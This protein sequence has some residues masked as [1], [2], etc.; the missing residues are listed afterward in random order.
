M[1][2]LETI[3]FRSAGSKQ[4]E[5]KQLIHSLI[6]DAE[7]EALAKGISAYSHVTVDTDFSIHLIH[8]TKEMMDNGSLLGLGLTSTLKEYG[9]VNHSIWAEMSADDKERRNES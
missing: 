2:Y 4:S 6:E 3:E 5:L 9:L 7:E 1:K 8:E